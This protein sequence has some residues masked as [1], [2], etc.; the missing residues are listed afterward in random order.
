MKLTHCFSCLSDQ[1]SQ[2]ISSRES[3]AT[4]ELIWPE[5]T[6]NTLLLWLLFNEICI[7]LLRDFCEVLSH[8][9]LICSD[10]FQNVTVSRVTWKH[11]PVSIHSIFFLF[12]MQTL[13]C[14]LPCEQAG[15]FSAVTCSQ[16]SSKNQLSCC[17]ETFSKQ[18]NFCGFM[19]QNK[20]TRT[21]TWDTAVGKRPIVLF[22]GQVYG[23][24]YNTWHS[25][26]GTVQGYSPKWIF[27]TPGAS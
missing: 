11:L 14:T 10:Y 1:L 24:E 22:P 15:F 18:Q 25:Y 16:S 27:C 12:H 9:F 21:K 19:T 8:V 17:W 13:L 5:P 20:N 2:R 26:E 3:Q 6:T 23:K 7:K 4:N